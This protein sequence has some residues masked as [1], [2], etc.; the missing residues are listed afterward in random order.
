[1][2]I[3]K[4]GNKYYY[5]IEVKDEAGNRK[6]IERAGSISKAETNKMWRQA[7]AEA[8][9]V[10]SFDIS[11]NISVEDFY[12]LWIR[13]VLEV[14][15][16]YKTNT[17]KLYKSLIRSHIL[18]R[19]G[20]YKLKR[21]T[22]RLLQNFLNEKKSSLS[23]SSLN[24]LVAVLKRSF[25]YAVDFGRFLSTSPAMNIHVPRVYKD[26]PD[27]VKTFSR[28]QMQK[29]FDK[30]NEEHKFYPAICAAYYLGFRIGECC[31]LTWDDIN[32]KKN[33]ITVRRTA[34]YDAG[35]TIQDLPKSNSSVRTAPFGQNFRRIL[36]SIHDRREHLKKEYGAFY[37]AG[38]YVCSLPNGEMITPDDLR[39]FNTWCKK[40][41][42]FGSFHTLR[43]TYATNMLEAGADLE[44]VSKQ[45]GHNSIVTTAK[46]YSHVLDKRKRL[47][48]D[49]MDKAL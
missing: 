24:C 16:S 10:G 25:I 34:V 48:A 5:T 19:F 40:N 33:E 43:H 11:S 39:Y 42:G 30:F 6:K 28:E 12:S 45:L 1:M 14:E 3:R 2:Y 29:I 27:P 31:A 18:P 35:W 8:D 21:I 49:L 37:S 13:E 36:L 46:Y 41:F 9:R 15:G 32:M 47:V 4:R 44:L 17:V 26:T 22:P 7:Q 23:R 38:N 20:S